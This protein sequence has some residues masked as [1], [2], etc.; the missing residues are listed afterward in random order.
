MVDLLL[1]EVNESLRQDKL[2][3]LWNRWKKPLL[4]ACAALVLGTAI[5]SV[6]DHYRA[7]AGQ[8]AMQALGEGA[9]AYGKGDY[10]AAEKQFH[11]L[12]Q[13]QVGGDIHDMARLWLARTQT[14][15][16]KTAEALQT[17]TEL[18]LHP[19]GENP[20]WQ[21]LACL[22]LEGLAPT[23]LPKACDDTRTSVL[24]SQ[25]DTWRA[26]RLYQQGKTPAAVA[27]LEAVAR[28]P[29]AS[30]AERA[31]AQALLSVF[32]AVEQEQ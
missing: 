7:K 20:I 11:G 23:A 13:R 10:A 8:V 26:A 9:R 16:Q 4:L 18:A 21:D 32:K 15:T 24:K 2:A 14:Q 5:N 6:R 25:R 22:R 1:S 27:V 12:V 29:A 31:Q 30:P 19:R 28:D 17:L 3:Q